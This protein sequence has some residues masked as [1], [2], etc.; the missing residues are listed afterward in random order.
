[1]TK[2]ILALLFLVLIAPYCLAVDKIVINGLFKNKAVVTI[3]GKQRVLNIGKTSPE[4]VKLISAN[5]KEAVIE[6]DGE[7]K[8]Y[9][10]GSHIGGSFKKAPEGVTVTITPDARGSYYVNG[11]INDF[12]VR[13]LVDTGATLI[14]MNKNMAKRIGLNYRLEGQEGSATTASGV[15]KMY[16]MNLKKVKVGDIELRDVVGAV[17]DGDFPDDILLGTSFLNKI[18]SHKEGR[19]LKLEK[20]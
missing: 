4:G 1:M 3:D 7:Q 9:E 6:V 15:T 2:K 13:F 14:F 17:S 12:Q 10:L 16:V 20:K 8:T 19:I 5:S 18:D 11:S